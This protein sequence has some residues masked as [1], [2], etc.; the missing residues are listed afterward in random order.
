MQRSYAR[1]LSS[2]LG[3][4]SDRLGGLHCLG[5]TVLIGGI[6]LNLSL[7]LEKNQT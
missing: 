1:G 7:K 2:K 6:K 5:I 4:S 3:G